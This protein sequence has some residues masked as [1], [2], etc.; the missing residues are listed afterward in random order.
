MFS[1]NIE[2]K[3]KDMDNLTSETYCKKFIDYMDTGY[4]RYHQE[5]E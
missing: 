3:E 2:D 5:M 1:S 4:C